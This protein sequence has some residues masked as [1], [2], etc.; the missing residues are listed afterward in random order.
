MMISQSKFLYQK[1]VLMKI[2]AYRIELHQGKCLHK[3]TT[4]DFSID[5]R[6]AKIDLL[7]VRIGKQKHF[8]DFIITGLELLFLYLTTGYS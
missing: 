5:I 4:N 8:R 2:G 1:V 7:I 6:I 3:Y